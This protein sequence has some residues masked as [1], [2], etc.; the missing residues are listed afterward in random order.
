MPG[1]V[2]REPGRIWSTAVVPNPWPS[3]F[4]AEACGHPIQVLVRSSGCN[5]LVL[6]M[7]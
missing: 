5:R 4:K 6:R 1:M 3:S 7:H 2:L